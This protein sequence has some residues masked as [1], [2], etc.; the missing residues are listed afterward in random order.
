[1]LFMSPLIQNHSAFFRI[2]L[3]NALAFIAPA[4]LLFFIFVELK[5]YSV[6]IDFK[7]NGSMSK[8]HLNTF[9]LK[10]NVE[11]Y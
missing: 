11:E 6:Q 7:I 9:L 5:V 10:Y 8:L 2:F 3:E 4:G 1:M